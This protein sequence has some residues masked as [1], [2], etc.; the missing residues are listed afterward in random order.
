MI[1]KLDNKYLVLN[2]DNVNNYLNNSEKRKLNMMI[3]KIGFQRA[4]E[5]KIHKNYVLVSETM[6]MFTDVTQM[7]LNYI[8][9]IKPLPVDGRTTLEIQ[10]DIE[11]AVEDALLEERAD[12]KKKDSMKTIKPAIIVQPLMGDN[13]PGIEPVLTEGKTKTNVK[14][15]KKS[16]KP[17]VAPGAGNGKDK[18]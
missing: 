10:A 17:K 7:V 1:T 12:V 14:V 18:S 16:T 13:S 15:Q 3:E 11:E 5:S 4:K 8:N 2:W 6:P 9:N